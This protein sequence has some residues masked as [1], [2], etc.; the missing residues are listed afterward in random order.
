[1][2]YSVSAQ[3]LGGEREQDTSSHIIT[4]VA[5]AMEAGVS[6]VT[7]SI[8]GMVRRLVKVEASAAQQRSWRGSVKPPHNDE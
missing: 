6:L 3:P 2:L 8:D 1:M 5:R 4:Q 7:N